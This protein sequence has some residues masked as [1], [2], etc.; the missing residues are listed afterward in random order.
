M[1]RRLKKMLKPSDLTKTELLQVMEM[2][3]G[4]AEYELRRAL[5]RIEVE[6]NDAHYEKSRRLID[7]EKKHYNA[8]F[9]IM[10]PYE[11]KPI[12]D[13]PPGVL[14]RAKGELDKA[15]AAGKEWNRLNG[16]KGRRADNG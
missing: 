12:M 14:K 8:Y 3:A 16:I 1:G 13:V 15:V 5:T 10:R 4:S 9:S 11:G 7:E 2:L 6:R